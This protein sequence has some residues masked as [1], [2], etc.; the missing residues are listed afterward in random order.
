MSE[1]ERTNRRWTLELV[2]RPVL[3]EASPPAASRAAPQIVRCYRELIVS[4]V[5]TED[6]PCVRLL[7]R[8]ED[9]YLVESPW[10]EPLAARGAEELIPAVDQQI[11]LAA[12]HL[13][14]DLFFLHAAVLELAGRAVLLIAESGAGKSTTALAL[15]RHGFGFFSDEL[16]P[17]ELEE[18]RVRPFPRA[19]C[20]KSRPPDPYDEGLDLFEGRYFAPTPVH[21]AQDLPV[22]ALLFVRFE[23]GPGSPSC[24]ALSPAAAVLRMGG[25]AMNM[26]AHDDFGMDVLVR[27]AEHAPALDVR[28]GDLRATA[29]LLAGRLARELD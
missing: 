20:L 5:E 3:L 4:G 15:V 14:P 6:T 2:G 21:A 1:A 7:D 27:L 11:V 22:A 8:G 13:R 19:I 16:A 23:P 25:Q 12:Q 17:L 26:L 9:R 28:T 10:T 24:E 29:E 18:L